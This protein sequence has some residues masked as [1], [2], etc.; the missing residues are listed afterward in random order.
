M[1]DLLKRT[2]STTYDYDLEIGELSLP[3]L[4]AV[5]LD[6]VVVTRRP[7]T[8]EMEQMK[9]SRDAL[10]AWRERQKAKKTGS[11][12]ESASSSPKST[13]TKGKKT[14]TKKPVDKNLVPIDPDG[15]TR[16]IDRAEKEFDE[17]LLRPLISQ[18]K[19]SRTIQS[20]NS[21]RDQCQSVLTFLRFVLAR[22][23]S[24]QIC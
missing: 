6:G 21:S 3:G 19:S 7:S 22:K 15:G 11:V 9:T 23:R 14:D 18:R 4:A 1:K 10:K 2:A 17:L 20:Q 5:R 16:D 13:D 8:D 12:N 24:S